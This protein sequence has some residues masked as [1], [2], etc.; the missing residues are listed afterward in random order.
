VESKW[1]EIL[2]AV[3]EQIDALGLTSDG[4]SLPVEIRKLPAVE[5]SIQTLPCVLV[6]PGGSP[7]KI[8]QFSFEDDAGV[9]V[10]YPVDV[11]I[12]SAGNRDFVSDVDVLLA[13]RQQARRCFQSNSLPG[14]DRVFRI[15][16]NPDPAYDRGAL[17]SN[18][19]YSGFSLEVFVVEQRGN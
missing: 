12:V 9:S 5:E 4:T 7:E 19:D 10:A 18:Y 2:T 6:A 3:K 17:N 15:L 14:V 1:Y 11:A 8:A 16:L 13:W